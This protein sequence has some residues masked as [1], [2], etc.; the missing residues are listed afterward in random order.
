MNQV[1]WRYYN[2]VNWNRLYSLKQNQLNPNY[3]ST[4]SSLSEFDA[5]VFHLRNMNSGRR[6]PVPDQRRRRP[7]QKYVMFLMESPQHDDFQYD[8]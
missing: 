4:Q 6:V 8:R 2:L 3:R 1:F 5:I 7:Q